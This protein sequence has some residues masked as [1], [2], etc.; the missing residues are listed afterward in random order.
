MDEKQPEST[1]VDAVSLPPKGDEKPK[2]SKNPFPKLKAWFKGLSKKQRLGLI[3]AVVVVLAGAGVGLA[4]L[5]KKPAPEP[6]PVAK[7]V[8]PKPAP[9]P[10]TEAS[11]LTGLEVDPALNKRPVTGVMIENSPEARPQ[12][13]LTSAGVVFEAIAEGGITRFLALFQDTQPDY[14]GPVRSVRPYYLDWVQGFDAPIAHAG[15]SADGLAKLK[16]D[17]VKD[18]DQF[19]NGKYYQRVSSRY[20]PH[21]LYTS[22]AKLDA[23]EASKGFT[24]ST[25]DGFARK[26]DSKVAT[27]TAKTIDLSISGYYYNPH[28]AYDAA[29]NTYKRSMQGKPHVDE[30]TGVQIAPKVVIA[31]IMQFRI[32]DRDGHS[33]YNTIGSGKSYIFQDGTVTIGTW[34]KTSSRAQMVFRDSAGAILKLNAG[35][36]WIAA[37]SNQSGVKYAP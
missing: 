35:Q 28:Y 12:S 1:D 32:I 29:T 17:K 19:A 5:L 37:V 7:K 31:N 36:T 34:E 13:G 3:V 24:S 9:K 15:G 10:T 8:E 30:K 23:L 27:P 14:I 2:A 4:Q 26:A 11:R 18:L 25:F 6:A 21:N 20:A 33:G 22:S 16:R